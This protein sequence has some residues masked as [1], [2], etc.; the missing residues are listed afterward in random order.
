MAAV[1]ILAILKI[2]SAAELTVAV[3]DFET[4]DKGLE[5]KGAQIADLLTA[6]LSEKT[7]LELLERDKLKTIL[8]E[9]ALSISGVVNPEDAARIGYITGARLLICGSAFIVEDELYIVA[10]V[11][12]TE[13]S[14][15]Y[16]EMEWG[17]VEEKLSRLVEKLAD[18]LAKSI[19]E[20]G[21][22]MLAPEL[23]E[24]DIIKA[25]QE[26]LKKKKLPKVAII[27]PETH[28]G[29][30]AVDPAVETELTYLLKKTGFTVLKLDKKGLSK[31]AR[32]YLKTSIPP[33]ARKADVITPIPRLAR[34]ADVIIVG[35]A[36]SEYATRFERLVSCKA[37]V[38]IHALDRRTG[39]VLAVERKTMAGVDLAEHIAAKKALEKAT[40]ELSLKFIP[41]MV[42]S[43]NKGL[44]KK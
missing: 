39:K 8:E 19:P 27:V 4:K 34:K 36:F 32:E 33:L 3:I 24:K 30:P 37:R 25:L 38:E 21:P 5:E 26:K 1:S 44:K 16:G 29:R 9:L 31:W 41:E 22:G 17:S 6:Y 23:K 13:T 42:D 11:I 35:Q 20:K 10:K 12:S 40:R 14:K 15:V 28:L 7:N 43:W 2:A 18:S